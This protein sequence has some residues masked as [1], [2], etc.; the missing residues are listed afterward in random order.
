MRIFLV[1]GL[2]AATMLTP[3]AASAADIGP[4]L[5]L[6]AN[7]VPVDLTGNADLQ[8]DGRSER[9]ANRGFTRTEL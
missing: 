1:T 6:A 8:R 4:K 9:R 7:A 3:A 2:M 5:N